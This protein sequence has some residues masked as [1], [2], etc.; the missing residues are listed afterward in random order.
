MK[1]KNISNAAKHKADVWAMILNAH[2]S[3]R[4]PDSIAIL[5][6]LGAAVDTQKDCKFVGECRQFNEL[7]VLAN[8]IINEYENLEY[9]S[10]GVLARQVA[11]LY[12]QARAI[13]AHTMKDGR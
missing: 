9:Q 5:N 3:L 7:L 1:R 10:A 6:E 4:D 8:A 2:P 12:H 11:S 13:I